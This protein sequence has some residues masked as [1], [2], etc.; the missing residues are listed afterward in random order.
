MA[1]CSVSLSDVVT[2]I[3]QRAQR[4]LARQRRAA[5]ARQQF[6]AIVQPFGDLLRREAV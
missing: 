2:P 4:L 3:D 1:R 5:T 6:E